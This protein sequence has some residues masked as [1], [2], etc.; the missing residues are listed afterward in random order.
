MTPIRF[1]P[2]AL[3]EGRRYEYL[4]RFALGGA[5]RSLPDSSVAALVPPSAV[6]SSRCPR[7]SA[8]ALP[9][10]RSTKCAANGRRGFPANGEQEAAALDA[11]GA[12]LGGWH[13]GLRGRVF[14]SGAEQRCG[15]VRRC[16]LLLGWPSRS[17]P[18][19]SAGRCGSC[20]G[21]GSA[22]KIA[23]SRDRDAALVD[24]E[25]RGQAGSLKQSMPISD[26]AFAS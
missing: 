9:G 13:A 15:R 10:S 20:A 24:P 18:G 17:G 21:G 6:S 4:I 25:R 5:R 19:S 11:A 22:E 12:A 16:F 2:S 26:P 1:S 8:P 14:D 3:R 23:A 7:S